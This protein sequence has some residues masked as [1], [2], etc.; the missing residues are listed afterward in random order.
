MQPEAPHVR[1]EGTERRRTADVGDPGSERRL[2]RDLRRS[3]DQECTGGRVPRRV[4]R[5]GCLARRAVRS[6]P[7]PRAR[8]RPR[9]GF[10]RSFVCSSSRSGYRAAEVCTAALLLGKPRLEVLAHRRPLDVGQAVPR[11]VAVLAPTDEHVVAMDALEG[12]AERLECAARAFVLRVGLPLDTTA[13]PDVERVPHLKVASRRRSPRCPRPTD[14]AMSSRSRPS[15]V[16]AGARGSE[17][18]RRPR[19]AH[20]HEWKFGSGVSPRPA[21]ARRRR[22]TPRA[23]AAGRRSASARSAGRARRARALLRARAGAARAATIR[24]SSVGAAPPSIAGDV[25][26]GS[27][28]STSTPAWSASRTS[29]SSSARATRRVDLPRVRRAR[30]CSKQLSSFAVHGAPSKPA[31]S[32][33]A[34]GGGGC[35]GGS[36]GC[37]H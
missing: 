15:G 6:P 24:P 7:S 25:T 32:G 12:R 2:C 29:R 37:G 17:S 33:P 22:A 28:R 8:A 23:S 31:F 36:C 21:P 35:C 4:R 11:A 10:A 9:S 16:R 1:I 5:T 14:E 26:L 3:R 20:G 34:G 27:C 18:S 30:R 13:A 19:R